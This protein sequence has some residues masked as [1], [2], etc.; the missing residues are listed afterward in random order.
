MDNL[1]G[2]VTTIGKFIATMIAGWV[3]ALAVAHNIHLG[4]SE[5]ELA[6]IIGAL[7]G[8]IYGYLDAKYPNSFNWLGNQISTPPEV[9]EIITEDDNN[10][11]DGC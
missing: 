3:I 6:E 11:D 5:K 8:L 10:D 1:K 2:N 7:I 9:Q 4:I